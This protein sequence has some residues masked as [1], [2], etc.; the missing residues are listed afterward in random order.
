MS[1]RLVKVEIVAPSGKAQIELDQPT[2]ENRFAWEGEV[3]P[4]LNIPAL[5]EELAKGYQEM[6]EKVYDQ[7]AGKVRSSCMVSLNG[8]LLSTDQMVGQLLQAGDYLQIFPVP[9]GG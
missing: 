5:L 1:K 7:A 6:I 3:T 2:P 8:L 4:G 9:F